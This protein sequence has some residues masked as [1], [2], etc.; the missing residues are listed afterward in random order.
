MQGF[1]MCL[2]AGLRRR[3]AEAQHGLLPLL[4]RLHLTGGTVVAVAAINTIEAAIWLPEP[5]ARTTLACAVKDA[6]GTQGLRLCLSRRGV[7]R[8]RRRSGGALFRCLDLHLL[9]SEAELAQCQ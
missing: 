2:A 4:A 8:F 6:A 9:L 5:S 1:E 3:Q 7:V